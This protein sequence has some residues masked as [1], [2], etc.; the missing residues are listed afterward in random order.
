M[1]GVIPMDK[2]KIFPTVLIVLDICAGLVYLISEGDLKKA[3]YWAAAA[4]LTATV[5]Y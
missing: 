3:L 4:I 1:R 5:T 2:T